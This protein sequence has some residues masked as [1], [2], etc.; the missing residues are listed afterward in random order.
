MPE[1]GSDKPLA[2]EF[3]RY[4]FSGLCQERRQEYYW[5]RTVRNISVKLV[6]VKAAES[7]LDCTLG[8]KPTFIVCRAVR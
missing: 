4:V 6:C 2:F 3:L 5:I 7:V 8:S 1:F